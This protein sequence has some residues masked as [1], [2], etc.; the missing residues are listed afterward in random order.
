MITSKRAKDEAMRE[1]SKKFVSDHN[2][3]VISRPR[4]IG[5]ITLEGKDFY[6]YNELGMETAPIIMMNKAECCAH[7]KS[8]T[9]SK[10]KEATALVVYGSYDGKN[11]IGHPKNHWYVK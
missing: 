10:M 8:K 5:V 9:K 6:N 1:A 2:S 7:I 11:F 3:K 4:T